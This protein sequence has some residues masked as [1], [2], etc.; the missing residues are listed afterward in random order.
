MRLRKQLP[1]NGETAYADTAA[2]FAAL[3]TKE[4]ESLERVQVR[5]RLNEEDEGWLAPLVRTD[6]RSGI[7]SLHSPVWASR[8]G[9]RPAIEVDGMTM[10]ESRAFLDRLEAHVLQAQFRYDHVHVP[11]DVTIWN[12]YMTLHNSPPIKTNISSID[13]ARVLYRLSCKGES[14]MSLPRRDDAQWLATHIAGGYS[15]PQEIVEVQTAL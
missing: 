4:Q 9:V 1:L 5:R 10:E 13:D 15:T 14:S 2:A 3:P 11:G 8:P 6:P 12:N 7:K